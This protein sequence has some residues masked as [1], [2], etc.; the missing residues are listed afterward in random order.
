MPHCFSSLGCPDFNLEQVLDLAARHKIGT[1]E[2]RALGGGVD[3][4]HYLTTAFGTPAKLAARLHDAPVRVAALDTSLPLIGATEAQRGQFLA[5]LP[6]TEAMG[7]LPLRVF[8]GGSAFGD[9][10]LSQALDT[11]AWW[12]R[13]QQENGWRSEIWVETHD[14]LI[15]T[16]AIRRF[17]EAAPQVAILWDAHHTWKRGGEDPA[18]TWAAI[19]PHVRHVHV[20][21]SVSIPSARHPYTYVLPGSG[22]FPMAKLI[23]CL[24]SGHYAGLVSLEWERMWHPY[25]APLEDALQAATTRRWW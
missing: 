15:D 5:Y 1:V 17:A 23:S 10:E 22:E 8:D 19:H 25:L 2:L 7:G 13:L 16:P 9:A 12:Q 14:V 3:L 18:T 6:W 24:D 11:L 21:D 4:P 20:K